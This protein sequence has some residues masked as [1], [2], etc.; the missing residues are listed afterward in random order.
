M[1]I[2]PNYSRDCITQEQVV[3]FRP[4]IENVDKADF[5]NPRGA[6][7]AI[8]RRRRCADP[9]AAPP[10]MTCAILRWPPQV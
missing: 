10:D 1:W 3:S 8:R 2:N 4:N 6:S 7:L 5:G 9:V